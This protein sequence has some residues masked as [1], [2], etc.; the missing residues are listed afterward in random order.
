MDS[1]G[2]FVSPANATNR[3]VEW[4]IVDAGDSNALK[5]ETDLGTI[6]EDTDGKKTILQTKGVPGE[7]LLKAY[8]KNGK[9]EGTQDFTTDAQYDAK[10]TVD[11][12]AVEV[13]AGSTADVGVYR[14]RKY[15]YTVC[16]SNRKFSL[17]RCNR[18]A[19]KSVSTRTGG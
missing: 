4:K 7:I 2:I 8:V 14:Q 1:A 6:I 3:D 9:A 13:T 19:K 17:C 16:C 5:D 10:V 11:L 12:A 18:L 15:I